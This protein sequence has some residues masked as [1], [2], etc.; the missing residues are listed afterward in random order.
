MAQSGEEGEE[1]GVYSREQEEGVYSFGG[2][3]RREYLSVFG[4]VWRARYSSWCLEYTV[5]LLANP[6]HKREVEGHSGR[7]S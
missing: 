2:S 4:L 7:L 1:E 5:F 3:R 6:K